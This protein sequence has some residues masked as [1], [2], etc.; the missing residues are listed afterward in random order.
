MAWV[1]ITS[2]LL[3]DSVSQR[4]QALFPAKWWVESQGFNLVH[5]TVLGLNPLKLDDLLAS[6]PE[7]MIDA[8]DD[9][10]RTP[11]WWTALRGDYQAM[12]SLLHYNVDTRKPSNA[13]WSALSTAIHS[14]NQQSVRLLL[15]YSSDLSRYDSHGWLALHLAAYHGL[16]TDIITATIPLGL[17]IDTFTLRA[18]RNTALILAA[19]QDQYHACE[20]LLSFGANPNIQNA[21][22]QTALHKAIEFKCHKIIEHLLRLTD[23]HLETQAGETL[24]DFAAQHSDIR[25]LEILNAFGLCG[26]RTDVPVTGTSPTQVQTT[27][28]GLTA[29]EIAEQRTN[30]TPEWLTT[31]KKLLHNNG[32]PDDSVYANI[33]DEPGEEYYDAL[34]S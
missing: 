7:S 34:E 22:G 1:R 33:A 12:V 26:I 2:G 10:G 32:I 25:S 31:F 3:E 8:G 29:L 9:G 16:D 14:K 13:G 20:C 11:L 19:Q 27:V 18:D 24:L 15:Q 21:L 6:V 4:L 23:V 5:K 30:V 17:D 28:V